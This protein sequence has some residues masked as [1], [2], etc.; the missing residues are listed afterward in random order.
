MSKHLMSWTNKKSL[1]DYEKYLPQKIYSSEVG[2]IQAVAPF[3]H[4]PEDCQH[5]WLEVIGE[6]FLLCEGCGHY[7]G[8]QKVFL[9]RKEASQARKSNGNV[10]KKLRDYSA[11]KTK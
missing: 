10:S 2:R 7:G 8:M 5:V 4:T 3:R 1:S 11:G 6:F 9:A